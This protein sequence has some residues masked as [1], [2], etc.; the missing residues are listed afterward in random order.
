MSD[1]M[2]AGHG[3]LSKWVASRIGHIVCNNNHN[4][5]GHVQWICFKGFFGGDI[6]VLNMYAPSMSAQDRIELWDELL[7][8][9]L[10]DYQ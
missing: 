10:Q 1:Q 8:L 7:T 4:K 3:G 2:L 9:L 6:S 5:N